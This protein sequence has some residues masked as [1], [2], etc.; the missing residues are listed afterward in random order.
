METKFTLVL[1]TY[2]ASDW[3]GMVDTQI[4]NTNKAE[5]TQHK[6]TTETAV[7]I[8]MYQAALTFK[9]QSGVVSFTFQRTLNVKR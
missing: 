3:W 2:G 1:I 8:L 9:S 7:L 5:E 6:V 4:L